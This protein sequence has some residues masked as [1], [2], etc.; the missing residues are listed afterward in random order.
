MPNEINA[1]LK[2]RRHFDT[3]NEPI[4]AKKLF[5]NQQ[6]ALLKPLGEGRSAFAIGCRCPP[7]RAVGKK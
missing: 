1:N 4:Q 5:C 3:Q 6:L 2:I 7:N